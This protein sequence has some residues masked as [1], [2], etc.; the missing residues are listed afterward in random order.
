MNSTPFYNQTHGHE[1]KW[2]VNFFVLVRQDGKW[3]KQNTKHLKRDDFM[4]DVEI[5]CANFGQ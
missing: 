2:D 3:E 5:F 1:M 4:G